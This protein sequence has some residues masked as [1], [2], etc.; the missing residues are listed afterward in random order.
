MLGREPTL[1]IQCIVLALN[2]IQLSAI[3]MSTAAHTI[4]AVLVIG[5]GAI[6]NRSQ[7]SPVARPKPP[8][9]VN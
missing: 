9:A 7:V 8:G 5:L 2:A 6:V 1:I 3:S 4:V